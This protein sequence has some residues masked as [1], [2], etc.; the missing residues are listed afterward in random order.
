MG[1]NEVTESLRLDKN[2]F[3]LPLE[4]KDSAIP[5]AITSYKYL[6]V[7]VCVCVILWRRNQQ[8]WQRV[9]LKCEGKVG[10]RAAEHFQQ[11][12]RYIELVRC[13]D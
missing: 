6:V 3:D 1:T 11:F 13:Q 10:A 4:R 5:S 7:C 9:P 12:E 8:P 2:L